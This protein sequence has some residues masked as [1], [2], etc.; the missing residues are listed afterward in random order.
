[1]MPT[2]PALLIMLLLALSLAAC[3]PQRRMPAPETPVALPTADF[4]GEPAC[5][6]AYLTPAGFTPDSSRLVM[7]AEAGAQVLDLTRGV[8][9]AQLPAPSP[10]IPPSAALSADGRWLAWSLQDHS[11]QLYDLA[12]M[13]LLATMTGH[14]DLVIRLRFTPQSDRLVSAGHDGWVR[15]WDMNGEPVDGFQPGGGE[16]LGIG[17]SPDGAQ[18]ATVPFDGPLA[19]WRFPEGAKLAD[20]GG[21]GGFDTS[22]AAFSPDGALL[23]ADLASGLYLWDL[24][25]R[26]VLLQGVNTLAFAFSPDGGYLAYAELAEQNAIRMTRLDGSRE[27]AAFPSGSGAICALL[28]SPNG[29]LLAA[30]D[31]V[32]LQV[33]DVVAGRALFN[34]QE[35][36]P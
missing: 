25:S 33:W 12:E 4:P 1:M 19:L 34:I 7:V 16:V 14:T 27:I 18:L 3:Q 6:A 21:G 28:V 23:A 11:I 35:S 13:R 15:I 24:A 9:A 26:Q 36:C 17:L 10:I 5:M 2:K 32:V 31:G 22:D 29:G 30:S 8:V 20:L